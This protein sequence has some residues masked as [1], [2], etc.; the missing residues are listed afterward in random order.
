MNELKRVV[1]N[2]Q[3]CCVNDGPGIRTT[4]F[5]KGC[6]LN[7][8]WCHNPESKAVKPQLMLHQNKC[9]GCLECVKACTLGLHSFSDDGSHFIDRE[10]C[11]ACGNCADACVGALEI[12]GKEMTVPEIIKEVMKDKAFYDNSGGGVTLSGGDPLLTPDFTLAL[13]KAAKE[14]GLHTCIE[15]CGHAKWEDVQRLIPYVDIFL[16]DVKETDSAL[17]KQFTGVPNER[18]LTNLHSLSEAGAHIIL[19]CPIIPGYNDRRD[20]LEAIGELAQK[21]NGVLQIE[22]EPYHPLGASKSADIGKEYPLP[23]ISF[24]KDET[25]KEWID[26]ISKK[27]SKTV[28]KA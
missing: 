7:C 27:T 20:H 25:V 5:L 16:W 15:T 12:C 2:I 8:L 6:M 21:L 13:L 19:R 4:V 24:Q 14:Q 23:D 28:K 3:K 1:F 26:I 18:I 11:A 10:K 9:I 22:V 17:H